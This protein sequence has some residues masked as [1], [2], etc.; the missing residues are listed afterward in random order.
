MQ[1]MKRLMYK[2]GINTVTYDASEYT[3]D[4]HSSRNNR[5]LYLDAHTLCI[6]IHKIC[7]Y[8][9]TQAY[10]YVSFCV[11]VRPRKNGHALSTNS[12]VCKMRNNAHS[13]HIIH[14]MCKSEAYKEEPSGMNF[15]S[16]IHLCDSAR[17]PIDETGAV[18]KGCSKDLSQQGFEL[19][20]YFMKKPDLSH[21]QKYSR[22]PNHL[23]EL[24]L[25]L[26]LLNRSR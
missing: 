23:E 8:V 4:T 16:P 18:I 12:F 10:V 5:H 7:T 11:C 20:N 26:L 14:T 19:K 13:L 6:H 24:Q 21:Y 9:Y 22:I 1:I 2:H 17:I 25:P 15:W 3:W